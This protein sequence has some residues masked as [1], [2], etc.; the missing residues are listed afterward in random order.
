M[1]RML[2]ILAV[3]GALAGGGVAFWKIRARWFGTGYTYEPVVAK[4]ALDAWKPSWP[5]SEAGPAGPMPAKWI[6]VGWDG[7]SWDLALPLLD[8]GKMPNLAALMREGAYGDMYSFKPTW[9]PVLWTSVATGVDP[10]RHGILAWGRVDK[11]TGQTRK[12]FTNSDRRVRAIWN[13]LTE[14]GKTS[15]VVGYH[16][17][18]PADRVQGLMVSNYLYQEHLE[19][20]LDAHTDPQSGRAGLVYPGDRLKEVLKIQHEVAQTLPSEIGRFASFTPEEAEEFTAPLAR[21]LGPGDD[22]RKYFLRKAYLFDTFNGRVA[23]DEYPKVT[24]DVML[25]H[26]QCIDLAGHYFFYFN[27]PSR[28]AGMTW[29]PAQR[30]ALAAQQRLY[31][32]TVEAFYRYADEWLGRILKLRAADTGV[33]LLSDH[34]FEPEPDPE[35]TGYHVSAPPG[36]FVVSGPGVRPGFRPEGATLYDV[37]PTLAASMGLP[38]AEDLRGTAMASWFTPEAWKGVTLKTVATYE[39]GGRYV[40]DVPA[41]EDTERELIQQLKAIGY[42]D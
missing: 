24:P 12:L 31:G 11:A 4:T 1:R 34:G 17:T 21:A 30:A 13:L 3:L 23:E 18:F 19:D 8:A 35:R 33:I 22:R 40:P 32:G 6:V 38:V 27:D 36:I 5:A 7:A 2:A 26:F 37:L 9:S 16:N 29:T 15:L 41:S 14:A 20:T 39:T 10:G 28:F 42:I 25:V